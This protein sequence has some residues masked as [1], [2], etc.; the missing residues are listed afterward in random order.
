MSL[1]FSLI[2]SIQN[3]QHRVNDATSTNNQLYI[4]FYTSELVSFADIDKTTR[5]LVVLNGLPTM[6]DEKYWAMLQIC[7]NFLGKYIFCT[8][9]VDPKD[10]RQ[11]EIQAN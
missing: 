8:S 2:Q 3:I 5:F 1:K 10:I 4:D 11:L 7:A 9:S 6:L